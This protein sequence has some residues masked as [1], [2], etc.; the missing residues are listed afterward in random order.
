MPGYFGTDVF[1]YRIV[2]IDDGESDVAT[3]SVT[4]EATSTP[5]AVNADPL[6]VTTRPRSRRTG[7]S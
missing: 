1:R 6:A 7:R 3:V 2:D 5:D 4:I